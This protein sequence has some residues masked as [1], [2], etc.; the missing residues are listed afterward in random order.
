[1]QALELPDR[2]EGAAQVEAHVDRLGQRVGVHRQVAERGERLLEPRHRLP[3]RGALLGPV[4][5]L[6]RVARRALP[7][8][9]P[10]AVVGEAIH[11][12]QRAPRLQPLHR[13]RDAGVQRAAARLGEAAV[14]HVVGQH[15]PERVL[16]VGEESRLVEELAGLERGQVAGQ[17]IAL[18]RDLLQQGQRHVHAHHR[19][20]LQEALGSVRQPVDARGQDGLH[21]GRDLQGLDDLRLPV[22]PRLP[23]QDPHL[24]EGPHRLLQEERVAVGELHQQPLQGPQAGVRP[25]QRL[26]QLVGGAGRQRLHAELGAD[27]QVG[28]AVLVL[29]S[30]GDQQHHPR[31]RQARHDL[32]EE[33]L[34]L[35]VDP[36]QILAHQHHRAPR[37]LAHQ[38]GAHSVQRAPASLGGIETRPLRVVA[39]HVEQPQER[40]VVAHQRGLER[41]QRLAHLLPDAGVIVAALDAEVL[42]E[43]IEHRRVAGP[44]RVR[45]RAGLEDHPL[46]RVRGVRELV[47]ETRLADPGLPEHRH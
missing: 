24:A 14:G 3:V 40:G 20:G 13:L 39:R 23:R 17:V 35:G 10:E 30:V 9:A 47:T 36:V 28:P 4:A 32:V 21:G 7:S 11:V 37:A 12:L 34:G 25:Q 44:A 8:L 19:G 16:E 1:V 29:G 46:P 42:P 31:G 45:D 43:Q 38:E 27:R 15:V 41:H 26:E 5:R 18:L 22:G 6:A 33:R 2:V